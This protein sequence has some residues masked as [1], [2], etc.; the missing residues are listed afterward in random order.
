MSNFNCIFVKNVIQF[1]T[2]TLYTSHTC[3]TRTRDNRFWTIIFSPSELPLKF[4]LLYAVRHM[5]SQ[6]LQKPLK[7]SSMKLTSFPGSCHFVFFQKHIV[8]CFV[9]FLKKKMIYKYLWAYL[10]QVQQIHNQLIFTIYILL[11]L[12]RWSTLFYCCLLQF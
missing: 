12:K 9:H 3:S 10:V 6:W 5:I 8:W 2:R 1:L 7:V 11:L 4:C